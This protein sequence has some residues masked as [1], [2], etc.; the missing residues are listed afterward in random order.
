MWRFPSVDAVMSF[1]T[2]I[3]LARRHRFDVVGLLLTL[4]E[5]HPR[6]VFG[7]EEE[8]VDG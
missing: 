6:L 1:V 8:W 2:M 7:R 5:I 4:L 3:L